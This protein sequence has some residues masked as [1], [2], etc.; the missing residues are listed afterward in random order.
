VPTAPSVLLLCRVRFYLHN[1]ENNS[2]EFFALKL[3]SLLYGKVKWK[4][5]RLYSIFLICYVEVRICWVTAELGPSVST[6]S[7]TLPM[8]KWEL[9]KW[10]QSWVLQLAPLIAC[11][12]FP[13]LKWGFVKWHQSW[14]HQSSVL[15]ACYTSG[16]KKVI[17]SGYKS[18]KSNQKNFI[19]LRHCFQ[20]NSKHI[21]SYGI[22]IY[23]KKIYS[24]TV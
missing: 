9:V 16:S 13:M 20:H 17:K 19:S 24:I 6:A 8:L 18:I 22:F 10:H 11:Y 21:V 5:W 14:V 23:A 1:S 2:H 3:W 15:I 4:P 7:Y 12:T